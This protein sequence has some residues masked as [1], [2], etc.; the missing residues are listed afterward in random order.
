MVPYSAALDLPHALVESVT[1]LI[2]THE[3]DR[4]CK[5]P[6]HQRALVRLVY[7]RAGGACPDRGLGLE[8][9]VTVLTV[10]PTGAD[11][12]YVVEQEAP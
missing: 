4:R 5:L 3:G 10:P 11:Y 12:R 6:P 8:D 2:V 1:M 9:T 7:L